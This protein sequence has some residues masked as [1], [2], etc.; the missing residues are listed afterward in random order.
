V[1]SIEPKALEGI[2][3]FGFSRVPHVHRIAYPLKQHSH[4]IMLIPLQF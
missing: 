2:F 3:A 4:V 1:P